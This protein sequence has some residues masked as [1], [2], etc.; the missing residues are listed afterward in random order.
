MKPSL[1][2]SLSPWIL[3]GF[4]CLSYV[5]LF[6]EAAT[7]EVRLAKIFSDSM[8][9]QRDQPIRIWG[10]ADKGE[11]IRVELG[12]NQATATPNET[13]RWEVT[14][15]AMP[16]TSEPQALSVSARSNSGKN[17]IAV[18]DILVGEVWLCSGQSNMEWTVARSE[19]SKQEIAAATDS[20]IRH[21][22][23]PKKPSTTPQDDIEASW[24]VCSPDTAGNFTACG[25]FMARELRKELDV[26]IGLINSSWGGTRVEPWV[27]LNG[28]EQV[29]ALDGIYQ[30]V[31]GRTPGMPSYMNNLAQHIDATQAWLNEAKLQISGKKSVRPSPAFPASLEP[32]KGHQD[33]TM[34]YNGMI[35]P[36]V[37][38][39]IRGAIWYQ[40]ESNHSEG[41]SYVDKK[42]A[43]IGGWRTLWDQG[44]FPFYYVQI[45][46]YQYGNEDPTI[47]PRFWETQDAVRQVANTE[48]IVINDVATTNDIHPTNKQAVGKRLA[49][50]ALKN[51]YG[52]DDLVATG[53]ELDSVEPKD[54]TLRVTFNNTAGGLK[55]RDGLAAS[56]FEIVGPG[57]SGFQAA[58]AKLDG[59]TVVLSCD[60]VDKP[61]AFRFA[62]HKTA[63]PNLMGGTG[64]PVGAV[65]GGQVPD[66]FSLLPIKDQFKLVFDL[67]LN[68]LANP[69]VY[70]VDHSDQIETF[71]RVGYLLELTNAN[72]DDQAVFVTM[73]PF[74]DDAAK[75]G[76]PTLKSGASFQT[77]VESMN[78]YS[79]VSGVVTGQSIATGNI[80]FWPNNYGA[81][82]TENV[83][84]ASSGLFDYGDSPGPPVDGYGSMQIHNH[85]AKQTLFSLNQWKSGPRADIGIGNSPG[86]TR[87]WTFAKNAST[88]SKKRL[89]VYVKP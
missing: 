30:S 8:V 32:F 20:L 73:K 47:L 37:G 34:L 81:S 53:P 71:S 2:R 68:K 64:L 6:A 41:T 26:P 27:P 9:L 28:F 42:K 57:A 77:S 18:Q 88:Y 82:N 60:Q 67:D 85:G 17:E 14:L 13:G 15:P 56:H 19:N 72:G 84:G 61:T 66:F 7:A 48:M 79:N 23:V 10:W 40:G 45:G 25:Y 80:E 50:V 16:A 54:G 87:D 33:P 22:K 62:W 31:M 21:I 38:Y 78:V 11:S 89:R 83:S 49:M 39:P 75:L 46:P 65:R 44:D 51:D 70:D 76:V 35:H 12:G 86:D 24:E 58:Q 52:R 55:T 5:C 36:L 1:P 4:L 43:L 3:L 63:E 69:L 59:N 29:P 74:T